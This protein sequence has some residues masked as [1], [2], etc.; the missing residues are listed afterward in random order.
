VGEIA[1]LLPDLTVHGITHLDALWRVADQIAG[2][3]YP[4]NPA[5]AF[6]LGGAFLLH[7]AAHVL[8][9]YQ[10]RLAGI[11]QCVQW[12]D[13]IAQQ[14]SAQEPAAGSADERF[15]LFQILRQL[16]AERAHEL[17]NAHWQVP[18]STEK[19]YLLPDFELR[20]YYGDLI[21]QIAESHHWP[22]HRV[23]DEFNERILNAP[24]FLAPA[25]WEVDALKIAFLLRTADAAHIDGARAP[26]FLF[27][28]RQPQGISEQ[29]WRFQ[30]KMGQLTRTT[31]GELR[32]TSGKPFSMAER[33]AW[34]LA[35]DTAKMIDRELR[36]ARTSL[37]ECGR[38]DF[39]A[40][41]CVARISSSQAFA[42][43]VRTVGWEPINVEPTIRNVPKIIANFGGAKL[44]GD[45]PHL[46]LRELIQN[47]AD[48]V[49]ALRALKHIGE[50]EGQIEVAL[51]MD[52]DQL[53]LHVTDQGIGMSR[54][55]L[56]EV[57]PD[58][59]NSLWGSDIL[60][61]EIPGLAAS[62]FQ[63]VGQFGIGFF[64]V[65][66]L[67][68]HVR[69]TTRR[70]KKAMA[71]SSEQWVLEFENHLAARPLLRKPTDKEELGR[72][73]T[74]VSVAIAGSI[75]KKMV[76]AADRS[77]QI[78]GLPPFIIPPAEGKKSK[79]ILA[80]DFGLCVANLC[81]TLDIDVFIRIAKNG[82]L[83]TIAANDWES[84][85]SKS[86]LARLEFP[87]F[88]DDYEELIDLREPTGQLVG[89]IC[90]T[91]YY[92]KA[93]AS[94]NGIFAGRTLESL[95]GV[96]LGANNIDLARDNSIP[97]ATPQAWKIWAG[98]MIA[99]VIEQ[100]RGKQSKPFSRPNAMINLHQFVPDF[101]VPVYI[102]NGQF[103]D[104]DTLQKW[105]ACKTEI[106]LHNDFRCLSS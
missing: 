18:G 5:E 62:G 29:H 26:W 60:R 82:S 97:V 40:A 102:L 80:V 2:P 84:I 76:R 83:K 98:K 79:D 96:V 95:K 99:N 15:A 64:A 49:R 8:A 58:F 37:Q 4:I 46:A 27:A 57:L 39:F 42:N 72:C 69:V 66:M 22:A 17:P 16:H 52:G 1:G 54:H 19:V 35:F 13:L 85:S 71:D 53:W 86:L 104:D 63:S 75:L 9:A 34:W 25:T 73:G 47:A 21:G 36:D 70:F 23:A 87:E 41:T 33:Q 77:W 6:V 90:Y 59:G 100:Y 78:A 61:S 106:K 105:V 89:R 50:L 44:Y 10:D 92:M 55:V 24:A 81:P 103:L 32:I 30:A 51:E 7:D 11:K 67:G 93:F 20:D 65:F 56:T 91:N 101:L 74:R 31:E 3:N 94:Y 28:L 45:N 14:F 48:A 88:R 43:H 68:T 12:K 38:T